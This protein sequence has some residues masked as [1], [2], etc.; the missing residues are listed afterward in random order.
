VPHEDGEWVDEVITIKPTDLGIKS[1]GPGDVEMD[2]IPITT[3][4]HPMTQENDLSGYEVPED[5]PEFDPR[6]KED[7]EGLMYLGRLT[8]EFKWLGH[9]F[10][11][12]TLTVDEILEVGILHRLYS[13]TVSD[14]KA[15]QAAVVAACVITVDGKALPMPLS[16]E[17]TDT[18][19]INKF[20]YV[21]RSWYPQ[22]LDAIYERYLL[23]EAKVDEVI[24]AMGKVPGFTETMPTLTGT[25]V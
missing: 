13:E 9:H 24:K 1:T 11:I 4:P 19:L 2:S 18:D 15:Y 16:T 10:V 12:R 17:P 6:V 20:R 8:D 7:F 5:I 3:E 14:T 22:T 23:L 21:K 25:S